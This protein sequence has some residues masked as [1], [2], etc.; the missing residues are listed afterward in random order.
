[1]AANYYS[2]DRSKGLQDYNYYQLGVVNNP[3]N[4]YKEASSL[5]QVVYTYPEKDDGVLIVDEISNSEGTWYKLQSDKI[6]NG[7]TIT[8]IGDYNWDS[9][10][11][12]K[13]EQITKINN[14]KIIINIQVK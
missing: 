4:A 8:T 5:S 9:Y 10:V 2:F 11:Y 13:K 3:T 6:I 1:M 7:N 14:P 12:V